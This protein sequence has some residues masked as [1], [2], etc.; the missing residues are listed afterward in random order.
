MLVRHKERR[1]G[2]EYTTTVVAM[3]TEDGFVV[4]LPYGPQT[5]WLRNVLAAGWFTLEQKG[6]A[7]EVGELALIDKA[8]AEDAF[9]RWLRGGLH[10]TEHFLK[11]KRLAKVS[12]DMATEPSEYRR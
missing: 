1:S 2:K 4:P 9:P 5:D 11:G 10:R 12:A 8:N 3:P 6:V 7:Y